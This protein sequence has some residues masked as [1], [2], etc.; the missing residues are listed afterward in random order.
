MGHEITMGIGQSRVQ[1]CATASYLYNGYKAVSR[2]TG[3]TLD[4]ILLRSRRTIKGQGVE[5]PSTI[6][7]IPTKY[8]PSA[9]DQSICAMVYPL[10]IATE[11]ALGC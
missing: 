10:L 3:V 7:S 2:C 6:N 1:M 5:P 11:R 9:A 4:V 8:P